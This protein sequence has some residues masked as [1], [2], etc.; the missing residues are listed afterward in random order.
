ML[1]TR[2]ERWLGILPVPDGCATLAVGVY[3]NVSKFPGDGDTLKPLK[4]EVVLIL[5]KER[6][7]YT[8]IIELHK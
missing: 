6:D 1:S 8:I 2:G 4:S 3:L 5:F 7:S